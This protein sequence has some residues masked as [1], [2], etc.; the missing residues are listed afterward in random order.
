MT[1]RATKKREYVTEVQNIIEEEAGGYMAR[2]KNFEQV[3]EIIQSRVQVY[4]TEQKN[5]TEKE[6]VYR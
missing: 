1:K 3:S 5:K 2:Q 6:N 4:L